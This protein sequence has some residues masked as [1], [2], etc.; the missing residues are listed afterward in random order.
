MQTTH[1]CSDQRPS[2]GLSWPRTPL[3]RSNRQPGKSR[4]GV[5]SRGGSP[6][7]GS[8]ALQRRASMT[9]PVMPMAHA[10]NSKTYPRG[11]RPPK[12]P[13]VTRTR[14]PMTMRKRARS[15]ALRSPARDPARFECV[16][17]GS[18]MEYPCSRLVC[19]SAASVPSRGLSVHRALAVT[20]VMDR[21][22]VRDRP[23]QQ[24]PCC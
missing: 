3:L 7:C 11:R 17:Y 8:S 16:M 4:H 23:A 14:F 19:L 10:R 22:D 9:S 1:D 20:A 6:L 13:I 18:G 12:R 2:A 5:G 24:L 21:Y 15:A